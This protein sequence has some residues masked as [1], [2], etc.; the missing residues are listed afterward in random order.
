MRIV[1]SPDLSKNSFRKI[2]GPLLLLPMLV[3]VAALS[4]AFAQTQGLPSEMPPPPRSLNTATTPSDGT[5]GNSSAAPPA[6][7]TL[8]PGALIAPPTT[9][10]QPAGT[11]TK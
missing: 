1:A 6:L 2:L 8:Q 3:P 11:W 10:S 4:F 5:S 7:N 9:V